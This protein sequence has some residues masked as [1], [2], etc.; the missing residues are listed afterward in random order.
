MPNRNEHLAR[1]QENEEFA[2]SLDLTKG[3]YVDWAI[4]LLFYAAPHYVDAYLA[5]KPYHPQNHDSRDKEVASNGSLQQI[6]PD[7]RRLKDRSQAARYEIANFHRDE[8]TKL[9]RRYANIKRH[10][11]SK[12]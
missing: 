10:I 6:Y 12:L 8:F 9:Y 2:R 7:Y 5:I 11:D 4:T 3:F 1:A